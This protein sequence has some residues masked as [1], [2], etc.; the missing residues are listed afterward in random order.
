[1]V[2]EINVIKRDGSTQPFDM[3]KIVKV[4]QAAGLRPID[5]EDLAKNVSDWVEK[6]GKD[7]IKSTE[8]RDKVFKEFVEFMQ[9]CF[10]IKKTT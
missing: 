8:I 2:M 6:Q 1:M 3:E 10:N 4:V 7:S 9:E 5:A